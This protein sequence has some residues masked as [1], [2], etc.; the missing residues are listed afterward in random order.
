MFLNFSNCKL[1]MKT[2]IIDTNMLMVPGEF[3]VDIFEEIRRIMPVAYQLRIIDRSI[4]EL[5]TIAETGKT[6]QKLAAKVGLQLVKTYNLEL[7]PTE[8]KVHVDR[9]I[10]DH[11]D[12]DTIVATQ[13]AALKARVLAKGV[14]VIVLR[15]KQYLEL[16]SK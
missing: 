7:I 15:K 4:N 12:K 14:P 9:L 5:E 2:I 8:K 13:D 3:K 16:V 1:I 10:L 11:L 6:V